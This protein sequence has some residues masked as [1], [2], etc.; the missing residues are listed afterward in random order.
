MTLPYETRH[1]QGA[2]MPMH[3]HREPYAALIVDGAYVESSVDGGVPCRP[4][5]LVLHPAYHAH[6]DRFGR[7]GA[8]VLNVAL[9]TSWH[10]AKAEVFSVPNLREAIQVIRHAPDRLNELVSAS[11]SH[12]TLDLQD[13]QAAFVEALGESD[14]PVGSIARRLGVSAA[15]A[16]RALRASFGMSPQC[17]RRELRWRRALALLRTPTPLR[18]VAALADFA[19]QSH[20]T[21]IVRAHSGLT[22]TA[23]RRQIK[24]V[25]DATPDSLAK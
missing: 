21:R 19:D 22:P 23:L 9:S 10:G 5:T 7:H 12:E 17:L 16:S 11:T 8:R 25:Q 14:E 15:H 6:G 1:D 20:F 4:G 13:W 24:C 18:D 2:T 3:R